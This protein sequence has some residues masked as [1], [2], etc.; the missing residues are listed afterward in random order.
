M[1]GAS[2]LDILKFARQEWCQLAVALILA[3]ARG[4]TFPVFSIIYGQMFKVRA[5]RRLLFPM[6][7]GLIHVDPE[8]RNRCGKG[9]HTVFM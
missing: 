9:S 5:F 8:R 3:V 1:K 2:L 7:Y 6:N 4:M